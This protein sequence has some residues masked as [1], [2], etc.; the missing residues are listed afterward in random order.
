M[1]TEILLPL[2]L[3]PKL[4]PK[5]F[6]DGTNLL[7]GIFQTTFHVNVIRMEEELTAV[8]ADPANG[9][10]LRVARGAPILKIERVAYTF[11]NVAVEFR[12]SWVNTQYVRYYRDQGTAY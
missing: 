7:Y 9:K 8:A 6:P 10:L 11:N 4:S 12:E 3:F 5:H 1:V 2:E